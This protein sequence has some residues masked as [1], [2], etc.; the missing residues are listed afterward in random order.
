V[1]D[2]SVFEWV[3]GAI[4]VMLAGVTE[5]WR[6]ISNRVTRLETL[7]E[8]RAKHHSE[9]TSSLQAHNDTVISELKRV[10]ASVTQMDERVKSNG[11]RLGT[12]EGHLMS[13]AGH[14]E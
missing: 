10:E 6:R 9:L 7:E 3:L 14:S 11:R 2:G 8:Q 13:K 4:G 1:G 5:G 12:L